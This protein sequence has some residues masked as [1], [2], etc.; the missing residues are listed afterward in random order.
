MA[1]DLSRW[2]S[3]QNSVSVEVS[4]LSIWCLMIISTSVSTVTAAHRR[5]YVSFCATVCSCWNISFLCKHDHREEHAGVDRHEDADAH[6]Q[7]R[8]TTGPLG[9]RV[10]LIIRP[11]LRSY[12]IPGTGR[13]WPLTN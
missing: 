4:V 5:D 9:V 11:T 12:W 3:D 8:H 7:R 10:S 1:I 13:K 2:V 6:Q